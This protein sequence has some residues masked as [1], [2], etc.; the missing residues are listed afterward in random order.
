MERL[1]VPAGIALILIGIIL[2]IASFISVGEA[3][4]WNR[5]DDF[6]A[7]SRQP[8]RKIG[9]LM[10]AAGIA[11]LIAVSPIIPALLHG[12][13]GFGL[14]LAG[15]LDFA[16]SAA[17]FVMVL[18]LTNIALPALGDLAAQGQV[19]P[20]RIV[21]AF[22]RQPAIAVA[23]LGGNVL[24]LS[25]ILIGM[26]LTRSGL[27]AYWLGWSVVAGAAAGWL[28]FLHVPVF[29]QIGGQL[30]PASIMILGIDSLRLGSRPT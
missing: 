4:S 3:R 7:D 25:W 1:T 13:P 22:V 6:A 27:F 8:I 12:T 29:Q 19:S 10:G 14:A 28:S 20:Q 5:A 30:W 9:M 15:W 16:F 11:A 17:L 23:F 24:F 18:G 26:G 21:D 2:S